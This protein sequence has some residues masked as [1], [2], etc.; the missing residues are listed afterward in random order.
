MLGREQRFVLCIFGVVLV[1]LHTFTVVKTSPASRKASTSLQRLKRNLTILARAFN[2]TQKFADPPKQSK[3]GNH[4][5]KDKLASVLD[6][7]LIKAVA[8]NTRSIRL[9]SKNNY[10]LQI[11]NDG[12]VN[13]TRNEKLPTVMFQLQLVCVGL[14]RIKS[15]AT[16][17][18]LAMQKNGKLRGHKHRSFETLFITKEVDSYHWYKSY[19][20]KKFVAIR[21]NGTQK[22][23]RQTAVDQKAVLFLNY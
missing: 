5:S 7:Y 12:F 15:I 18:Y 9:F 6:P 22:P 13:G 4:C 3:F 19:K 2:V 23:A 11:T 1:C 14:V 16:G 21:K 17:R 20:Y 10:F 8:T